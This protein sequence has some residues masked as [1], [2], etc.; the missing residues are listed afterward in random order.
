MA[1]QYGFEPTAPGLDLLYLRTAG[2]PYLSRLWLY[3]AAMREEPLDQLTE[4]DV[5]APHLR[6]LRR[7]VDEALLGPELARAHAGHEP[8]AP[9]APVPIRA[10]ALTATSP[11]AQRSRRDIRTL[12]DRPQFQTEQ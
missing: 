9:T 2:H 11:P 6:G 5:F 10:S 3:E 7:Q 4:T 12:A 8:P 1:R